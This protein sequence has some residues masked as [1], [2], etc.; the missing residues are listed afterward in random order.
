M[1]EKRRRNQIVLQPR[2]EK[3]LR[4]PY[5]WVSYTDR[6]ELARS[7]EKAAR[8]YW[9]TARKIHAEVRYPWQACTGEIVITASYGTVIARFSPVRDA[10]RPD[11]EQARSYQP[12]GDSGRWIT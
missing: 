8:H 5:P 9:P 7:V 6:A 12:I 11:D 10:T 1:A 4:K 2:D 3:P